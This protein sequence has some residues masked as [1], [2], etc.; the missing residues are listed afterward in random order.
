MRLALLLLL[1]LIIV[2][3]WG[4][5]EVYI[6]LSR[7]RVAIGEAIGIQVSISCDLPSPVEILITGTGGG[8]WLYEN[9]SVTKFNKSW[10][11]QIPEDWEE[12]VYL[13]KVNVLENSTTKEFFEQFR[14]IKPKIVSIEVPEIPYQGR[15]LVN[16]TV[17]TPNEQN[18]SLSFRFIGLN[19]RFASEEEYIPKDN[20]TKLKLNLRERFEN[21]WDIDYAINPGIYALEVMLKYN[22]KLLDSRIVTVEV[23]RPKISVQVPEEVISGEPIRVTISS[24]RIN[25]CY[26]GIGYKGIIVTLVG[27]NYKAVRVVE[28]DEN[29]FANITIETAGLS[30]GDYKLYVRDTALTYREYG[31]KSLGLVYYDLEPKDPRA[32][33]LYAQDDLLII[34]DI[35]ITKP[36]QAKSKAILFFEPT[37]Q[38][39]EEGE[40]VNYELL[41]SLPENGLSAYDLT[42][43]I[44]NKSIAEIQNIN[45][46]DWAYETYRVIS[47]DYARIT[48]L[49]LKGSIGKGMSRVE[50]ATITL[51]AIS[52]GMT[53]IVVTA[54][55]MDSD[56]G[57]PINPHSYNGYLVVKPVLV[58]IASEPTNEKIEPS[59]NSTKEVMEKEEPNSGEEIPKSNQSSIEH[60]DN[61]SHFTIENATL[62]QSKLLKGRLPK[63]KKLEIESEDIILIAGI[64]TAF[65]IL[66]GRSRLQPK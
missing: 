3:V 60:S 20:L 37:D 12:G 38:T 16:V 31:L 64:G 11:F 48:A 14:V 33:E 36:T 21:T 66:L 49:D 57:D 50:I 45:F 52:E 63:P 54:K 46:P 29:G 65:A 53:E 13:V 28:L 40:L 39:A 15:T 1:L 17:E 35:R 26:D 55:R 43:S 34:K 44:T 27:K 6:K 42:I 10:N 22:G 47:K 25:D 32:K 18:T 62:D 2:P 7:D 9:E 19:F 59:E 5:T 4:K 41:L 51:K 24:N 8:E 58:E 23:V 30:D 56:N 61:S